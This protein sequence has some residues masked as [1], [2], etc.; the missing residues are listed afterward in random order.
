MSDSKFI[1]YRE[2][3]LNKLETQIVPLIITDLL[4]TYADIK[5]VNKKKTL[6]LKEFQD[7]LKSIKDYSLT[8]KVSKWNCLIER[9]HK[10]IERTI[11]KIFQISHVINYDKEEW[12]WNC[13]LKI[14]RKLW[15]NPYLIY[16]IGVSKIEYQKNIVKIEKII[17]NS[18]IEVFNEMIWS[19]SDVSE[20]NDSNFDS[21]EIMQNSSE[22][23]DREN[24]EA[25]R[26]T[27]DDSD[28]NLVNNVNNEV[29]CE[30]HEKNNSYSKSEEKNNESEKVN[31]SNEINESNKELNKSH[32][33]DVESDSGEISG[34]AKVDN[35]YSK[36]NNQFSKSQDNVDNGKQNIKDVE[37]DNEEE[38]YHSDPNNQFSKSQDNVN[39]GKQNIR[40]VESDNEDKNYHS[41]NQISKSNIENFD[42][43]LKKS[44]I[45]DVESGSGDEKKNARVDNY[46]S[47]PNYQ[48]SKS[49]DNVEKQNY[50]IRDVESDSESSNYC[51]DSSG[52]ARVD[53]YHSKPNKN[54][55]ITSDNESEDD[56]NYNISD[57]KNDF[58]KMD[59]PSKLNL[60][61]LEYN[62][63][64]NSDDSSDKSKKKIKVIDVKQRPKYR[65]LILKR[66]ER[67]RG[68]VKD[69]SPKKNSFF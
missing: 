15:K 45:R 58:H 23:P 44:Y 34:D 4:G 52:N 43:E 2:T 61:D 17:K 51:S 3:L 40:D 36:P 64:I 50:Y 60:N 33:R 24:N 53:I 28:K 14:A 63:N 21:N 32:I 46:H 68:G 56:T 11:N 66:K 12:L 59:I 10:D 41:N 42:E 7:S 18:L 62:R 54:V 65:D 8:D 25:N 22:K 67:R 29:D 37:S 13:Y 69:G 31:C 47:V 39:N 16:D 5:N 27:H 55:I 1:F 19:E 49:K 26:E 9:A 35:Y 6:L 48:F 20:K 30:S 38:N 57:R